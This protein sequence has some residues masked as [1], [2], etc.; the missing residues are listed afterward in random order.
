MASEANLFGGNNF[1][2]GHRKGVRIQNLHTDFSVD[3]GSAVQLTQPSWIGIWSSWRADAEL[4][5]RLTGPIGSC[6][7]ASP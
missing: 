7:S 2:R 5:D 4:P 3:I 1:L 6:V